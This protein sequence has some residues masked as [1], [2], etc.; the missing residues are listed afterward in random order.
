[1]W[2]L[3]FKTLLISDWTLALVFFPIGVVMLIKVPS[4]ISLHV[5]KNDRFGF[6]CMIIFLD[7]LRQSV[8]VVKRSL[9][10]VLFVVFLSSFIFS[11]WWHLVLSLRLSHSRV[12]VLLVL[13]LLSE[14]IVG[15][16]GLLFSFSSVFLWVG[17]VI[18]SMIPSMISLVPRSDD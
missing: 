14:G 11:N 7:I 12:K 18:F 6:P 17:C 1:M 8:V 15:S 5:R 10:W 3:E 4:V 2:A 16:L 9:E 13:S